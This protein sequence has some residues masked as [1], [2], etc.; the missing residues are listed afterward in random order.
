MTWNDKSKQ[1]KHNL[2]RGNSY[3]ATATTISI[4]KSAYSPQ[5]MNI[6]GIWNNEAEFIWQHFICTNIHFHRVTIR[7]WINLS[8]HDVIVVICCCS[9]CLFVCLFVVVAARSTTHNPLSALLSFLYC[10]E[11]SIELNGFLCGETQ[12]YWIPISKKIFFC[13]QAAVQIL[14][15]TRVV[16]S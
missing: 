10:F 12:K 1:P 16:S 15:G 7:R 3:G 8:G 6:C 5:P 14:T 2:R 4:P 9:C 13:R 11:M